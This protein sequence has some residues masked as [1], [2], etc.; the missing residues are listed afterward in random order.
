MDVSAAEPACCVH[1][2]I[3]PR[4]NARHGKITKARK[5]HTIRRFRIHC[6]RNTNAQRMLL[7]S[8]AAARKELQITRERNR[9]LH[10]LS[11]LPCCIRKRLSL[12]RSLLLC[13]SLCLCCIRCI[14]RRFSNRPLLRFRILRDLKRVL[15]CRQSVQQVCLLRA[16][17][18]CGAFAK[19]P[20]K[21][22]CAFFFRKA[23][24]RADGFRLAQHRFDFRNAFFCVEEC[25]L[26]A[27]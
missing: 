22:R 20:C 4:F 19:E 8:N 13:S 10:R 7:G 5:V 12:H 11:H 14:A 1:N 3:C 21:L 6:T 2:R 23:F 24:V 16:E 15:Q 9:R 17:R 26:R 25:F 27:L 18:F